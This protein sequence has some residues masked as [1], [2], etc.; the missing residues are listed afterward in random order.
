MI[1]TQYLEKNEYDIILLTAYGALFCGWDINPGPSGVG[2]HLLVSLIP[3]L[4]QK[5]NQK[6]R[7][8]VLF[9]K[10]A[11]AQCCHCFG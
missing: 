10:L 8:R 4:E 6:L 9:L 3:M 1:Y 11:N 7:E 5:K 2:V